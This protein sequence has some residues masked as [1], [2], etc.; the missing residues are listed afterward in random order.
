MIVLAYCKVCGRGEMPNRMRF[1]LCSR[2]RHPSS[3]VF[4]GRFA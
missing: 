2:C 1:G 4:V 3:G